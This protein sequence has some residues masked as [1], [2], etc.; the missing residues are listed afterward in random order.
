MNQKRIVGLFILDNQINARLDTIQTDINE[1]RAESQ[2]QMN[3]KYFSF[4]F[5]GLATPYSIS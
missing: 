3:V 1:E 4:S 2:K 5:A